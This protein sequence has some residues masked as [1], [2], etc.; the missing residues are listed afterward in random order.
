M[1]QQ[2][3]NPYR[4]MTTDMLASLASGGGYRQHELY[5][6]LTRGQLLRIL[7]AIDE[8]HDTARHHNRLPYKLKRMSIRSAIEYAFEGATTF[9]CKTCEKEG[10][11]QLFNFPFECLACA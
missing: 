1:Y 5:Q 6:S 8:Q 4:N 10:P 2:T 11:Y 7:A 3:R 9:V